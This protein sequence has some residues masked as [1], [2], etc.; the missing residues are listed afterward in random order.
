MDINGHSQ[1]MSLG[2][3]QAIVLSLA[4]AVSLLSL[5]TLANE[6]MKA[7]YDLPAHVYDVKGMGKW[8]MGTKS[9]QVR[10]VITRHKKRDEV[11]LQW[12]QWQDEQPT[13]VKSTISISEINET[14][15]FLITFIRRE[16]QDGVRQI[17]L[18]LED[19]RTK[20]ALKAEIQVKEMGLYQCQI[21]R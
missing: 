5:Q 12:V 17:V 7:V 19:K 18:G 16:V 20:E 10:L 15:R 1:R 8:S 4:A 6:G 21:K 11:Y 9:G 13:E 3:I 2:F 14:D